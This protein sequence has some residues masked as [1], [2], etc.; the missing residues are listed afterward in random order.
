VGGPLQ[1]EMPSEIGLANEW[2]WAGQEM[3]YRHLD[4][5]GRYDEGN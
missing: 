5:N 1:I 2:N 3:G 4:L